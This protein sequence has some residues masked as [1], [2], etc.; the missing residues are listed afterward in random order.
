MRVIVGISAERTS[1]RGIV[2][3]DAAD[4][5]WP[6]PG[7]GRAERRIEDGA[8]GTAV[9]EVLDQLAAV[10]EVDDA[11]VVY[12]TAAE[13]R[14]L[15]T[16]LAAGKWQRAS[17]VSIKN[18]L[19]AVAGEV[20]R[21]GNLLVLELLGNHTAFVATGDDR[22]QIAASDSWAEGSADPEGAGA[23]I[24]RIWPLLD[25]AGIRPDAVVICGS[26]ADDTDIANV[27]ALG[28]DAPV[29]EISD[30]ADAVARGAAL[31]AAEQLHDMVDEAPPSVDRRSQRVVVAAAA[32]V[33]A[34]AGT[35]FMVAH[36]RDHAV[37]AAQVRMSPVATGTGLPATPTTSVL[38]PAPAADP[39]TTID[40]PP[41]DQSTPTTTL[42]PAP[43]PPAPVTVAR[44][45]RVPATTETPTSTDTPP[46][47]DPTTTTPTTVGA[48]GP[49]WLFPGESPPPAAGSDPAKEKAWWDT[50]WQLKDRWLHGE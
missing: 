30:P 48:P 16:A 26:A 20:E 41:P 17:Y 6:P 50:H 27:I 1:V 33:A 39:G 34:L 47:P 37:P 45:T 25:A 35:G 24:A 5:R 42:E 8:L 49:D 19:V 15:V 11:A 32:V 7:R 44:P 13:R 4:A 2:H 12:R 38:L 23:A 28:F 10:A 21:P 3:T 18:A 14:E 43:A 31:V 36:S 22:S 40:P 46:P 29:A 9:T